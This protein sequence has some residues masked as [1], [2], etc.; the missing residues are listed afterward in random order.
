MKRYTLLFALLLATL[1]VTAQEKKLSALFDY[2]TFY[3]SDK[4]TPYVETYLNFDARTIH[5]IQGTDGKYRGTVEIAIAVRKDDTIAYLKKYELL[6]PAADR[7]DADD[8]SFFDLQRF[9][10]SNGI[11]DMEITIHDKASQTE[12]AVI[13]EKLLVYYASN[14][15]ALSSI[16]LI[17]KATRTEQTNIFSRNGYDMVPYIDYFLPE[18]QKKLSPYFEMYN[19]QKEVGNDG[20]LV[21]LSIE[22]KETGRRVTAFD[23]TFRYKE[24]QPTTAFY[25]DLDI[26]ALPSGN[27]NLVAEVRDIH[28]EVLLRKNLPFQRSNPSV[29]EANASDEVVATSFAALITD[30]D[31]LN[32]YLDALYPISSDPEI[33]TARSLIKQRDIAAKQ[34]YLYHFWE[35]RDA[36]DPAGKWH[37]Y[38]GWL[39]YVDQTYSYPRTPGY[40][41]DRGRVYLQYGP[42]DFIRDEKN[43]VGALR[44]GNTRQVQ[45]RSEIDPLGGA[46]INNQGHVYYLPY[47]LWRYNRLEADEPN[48]VFLFWDQMR[49]GYYKLLNSNARGEVREANWEHRLS[50][51]QLDDDVIG[52]VGEQFDRGY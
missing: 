8:F 24:A 2:A 46:A 16:L 42:P 50:Q 25:S 18:T 22:Q 51:G 44:V 38:L 7:S 36:L 20:Y 11:Y 12:P 1:P 40:H 28:N 23:R 19:L 6:S 15:P 43:F 14:H 45:Q 41:T 5:L 17:G 10:L 21:Y 34:A 49:S 47:Q 29:K 31:K 35:R 30:E 27:Y 52:E 33:Q 48:R 37:E 32:Y 26:S 9:A 39:T 4:N 13:R 3:L